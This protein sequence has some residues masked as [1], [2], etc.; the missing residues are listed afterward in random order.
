MAGE[1]KIFQPGDG[2]FGETVVPFVFKNMDNFCGLE[3]E[4]LDE[5][6]Q[7]NRAKNYNYL[8]KNL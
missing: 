5:V 2:V 4:P 8:K 3:S 1:D 6:S 7:F